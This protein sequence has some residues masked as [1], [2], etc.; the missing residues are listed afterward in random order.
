MSNRDDVL[1]NCRP[2][3]EAPFPRREYRRRLERIRARMANEGID[4]LFVTAPES[5]NYVSGYQCEWY[6]A[7]SPKQWPA[8]SGIAIHVNHDRFIHF[9]TERE[10]VLT[11]TCSVAEDV[12]IFPPTSMRDGISFIVA[13]LKAEGWLPGTVGL[14]FWSYRPNRVLSHRFEDAFTA[15]GAKVVD[16]T[17]ILRDVRW[18]KSPLEMECIEEAGRIAD[19][20]LRAAREALR[21]GVSELEIYGVA[22]AAMTKA[23]GENPGIAMPVLS[24]Q[25]TNSPHALASR[26]VIQAGDLVLV[27]VCGVF[28][29]YHANAARSYSMGEPAQDVAEIARRSAG[30]IDLLKSIL[31]PNL[32]VAELNKT[33]MDYYVDQGLWQDRGWI[34]GYEMGIAFPPDWVGAF[35]FDPL[36]DINRERLFEPGTAVNY[37][38]QFFMPRREGMFFMIETLVFKETEAAVLSREP[39]GLTVIG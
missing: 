38:N 34:G 27:D 21:P 15:G 25:K 22:V 2:E 36:S 29:R 30:S 5:M 11:R 28:K 18:V 12:R 3:S 9:D 8:S 4:L 31:R 19:I 24:G 6:Q 26:K 23:G 17:D 10:A 13:E 1:K 7:Q 37:E 33:M 14:E 16:G 32:P 39:N 35:V 20:G